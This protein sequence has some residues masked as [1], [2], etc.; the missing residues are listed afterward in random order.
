MADSRL[1]LTWPPIEDGSTEHPAPTAGRLWLG[2]HFE[3]CDVYTRI[4]RQPHETQ[5]VGRCPGCQR[6]VAIKVGPGGTASR[7]FRAR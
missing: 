3:C 5:Y 7:I 1:D 6:E 4:Y 2:I